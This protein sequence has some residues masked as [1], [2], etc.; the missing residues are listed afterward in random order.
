M[1]EQDEFNPSSAPRPTGNLAET[2]E[3]NRSHD[4]RLSEMPTPLPRFNQRPTTPTAGPRRL[5]PLEYRRTPTITDYPQSQGS[6]HIGRTG[7]QTGDG[8]PTTP[9]A[10][11]QRAPGPSFAAATEFFNPS[12]QPA[13]STYNRTVATAYSITRLYPDPTGTTPTMDQEQRTTGQGQGRSPVLYGITFPGQLAAKPTCGPNSTAIRDANRPDGTT[14]KQATTTT[15]ETSE[16]AA[17]P[18]VTG[19]LPPNPSLDELSTTI[20]P[21]D[22]NAPRRKATT[23]GEDFI[24]RPSSGSEGSQ[25]QTSTRADS[26]ASQ[27]PSGPTSDNQWKHLTTTSLGK[28]LHS[29]SS[30]EQ[31]GQDDRFENSYSEVAQA[32]T[33]RQQTQVVKESDRHQTEQGRQ[34]QINQGQEANDETERV[35]T[36]VTFEEQLHKPTGSEDHEQDSNYNTGVDRILLSCYMGGELITTTAIR[37]P[38]AAF[39]LNHLASVF[40]ERSIACRK[41]LRTI[42]SWPGRR[43]GLRMDLARL[44]YLC[45]T[46]TYTGIYLGTPSW[47][48]ELFH[49]YHLS[50][51]ISYIHIEMQL[52]C[53]PWTK[54]AALHATTF[55]GG[56][57]EKPEVLQEIQ[58]AIRTGK[59]PKLANEKLTSDEIPLVG[60][61]TQLFWDVVEKTSPALEREKRRSYDRRRLRITEDTPEW[62]F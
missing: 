36:G 60:T 26:E 50:N 8:R 9:G 59:V 4:V 44:S 28:F 23:T 19:S 24:R 11:F 47:D 29:I 1:V 54:G 58:L 53:S 25:S 43:Y 18:A 45:Y 57:G 40:D 33:E 7:Q 51:G 17:N 61:P 39:P 10:S 3:A 6:T 21:R 5:E 49:I 16:P 15:T 30:G 55:G 37:D 48:P 12:A 31:T 41:Y 56:Y 38:P 46:K 62:R 2:A 27:G 22:T 32:D 14:S 52:A 13:N 42:L 35:E 34:D 20:F